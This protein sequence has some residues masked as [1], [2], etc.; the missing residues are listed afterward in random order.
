M[1]HAFGDYLRAKRLKAGLSVRYVADALDISPTYLREV[2]SG[3]RG[4]LLR[5]HW[6]RLP[7]PGVSVRILEKLEIVSRPLAINIQNAPPQYQAMILALA[8]RLAKCDLSDRSIET[9]LRL[10]YDNPDE[11]VTTDIALNKVLD[12]IVDERCSGA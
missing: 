9:I 12:V 7:I 3:K 1:S 4:P 2:E 10:L 8:R 6:G 11:F 5:R